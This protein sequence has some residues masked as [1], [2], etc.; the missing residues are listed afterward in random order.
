[1]NGLIEKIKGEIDLCDVSEVAQK[2]D[3]L[4]LRLS[5]EEVYILRKCLETLMLREFYQLDF[6]ENTESTYDQM[7]Y[8]KSLR[9][10]I[11][12]RLDYYA[13]NRPFAPFMLKWLDKI[14]KG[15]VREDDATIM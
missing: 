2:H 8:I 12:G 9:D 11:D 13:K 6:I 10:K 7:E 15:K 5:P 14:G 3:I 4:T 1:M